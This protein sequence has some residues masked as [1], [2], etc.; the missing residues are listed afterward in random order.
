MATNLVTLPVTIIPELLSWRRVG[1]L[2]AWLPINYELRVIYRYSY[3]RIFHR[4]H[5]IL[6]INARWI[7]CNIKCRYNRKCW[8]MIHIIVLQFFLYLATG[9]IEI[10]LWRKR[11][12]GLYSG[13]MC[14]SFECYRTKCSCI[15]ISGNRL[16]KPIVNTEQNLDIAKHDTVNGVSATHGLRYKVSASGL[17][18]LYYFTE[19]HLQCL[20]L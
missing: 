5:R 20:I 6:Y 19:L 7:D 2:L 17:D 12:L 16:C 18:L 10:A 1:C 11:L 9:Y 13:W 15:R 4:T 14:W 8:L 3:S